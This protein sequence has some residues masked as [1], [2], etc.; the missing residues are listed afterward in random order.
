MSNTPPPTHVSAFMAAVEAGDLN[1]VR[2]FLQAG[3]PVDTADAAGVTGLIRA[4]ALGHL[5]LVD[6]FID[7]G[8]NIN[9]SDNHGFTP[10]VEAA[11]R[12]HPDVVRRLLHAGAELTIDVNRNEKNAVLYALDAGH[13]GIAD[14]LQKAGSPRSIPLL[15]GIE[16]FDLDTRWVAVHAGIDPVTEAFAHRRNLRRQRDVFGRT[17]QF[18]QTNYLALQYRGHEWTLITELHVEAPV[19]RLGT[20]DA[21]ALAHL[22]AQK[23]IFFETSDLAGRFRYKFYH[24]GQWLEDFDTQRAQELSEANDLVKRPGLRPLGQ[25]LVSKRRKVDEAELVNPA[26]FV[27]RFAALQGVFIPAFAMGTG[28]TGDEGV[29]RIPSY[30]KTDFERID[31][32]G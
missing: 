11:R 12:G 28:K 21:E 19:Q 31:F 24:A 3:T 5:G 4:A 17:V 30:V 20:K 27:S 10:I 16:S 13:Q 18:T 22:L 23:A 14:L 8:A 9:R 7:A 1:R 26:A 2:N 29:M 32:L 15:R 25:M 6:E